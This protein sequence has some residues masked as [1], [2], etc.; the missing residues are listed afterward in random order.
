MSLSS[1]ILRSVFTQLL[2]SSYERHYDVFSWIKKSFF[3]FNSLCT[4]S[5]AFRTN[6]LEA[7]HC[8]LQTEHPTIS[9]SKLIEFPLF[10]FPLNPLN[11][12]VTTSP[13]HPLPFP[14]SS[15]SHL[16][17]VPC[18]RFTEIP[19][20]DSFFTTSFPNL[21]TLQI[22]LSVEL[23][24]MS[25]NSFNLPKL[26]S[27]ILS[28]FVFHQQL[29]DFPT[30]LFE[31]KSIKMINC[32][33]D[34][35]IEINIGSL[36]LLES[37][38][39]SDLCG[40]G[41]VVI[42]GLKI[43]LKFLHLYKGVKFNN[44]G[45][46]L[47]IFDKLVIEYGNDA[48]FKEIFEIFDL[49]ICTVDL[50]HCKVKPKHFTTLRPLIENFQIFLVPSSSLNSL[51]TV[52]IPNLKNLTF[53]VKDSEN[54]MLKFDLNECKDY[55][56]ILAFHNISTQIFNFPPIL[57]INTLSISNVSLKFL[58]QLLQLTPFLINLYASNISK[59]LEEFEN[60]NLKYLKY[61]DL[62]T[63]PNSLTQIF[64]PKLANLSV[65]SLENFS[66]SD[67][68]NFP[69]LREVF[70]RHCILQDDP[71]ENSSIVDLTFQDCDVTCPF[72]HKFTNLKIL[73]LNIN[74][75]ETLNL[76][77]PKSIKSLFYYGLF[78]PLRE[79]ISNLDQ[80]IF[81][82]G[83]I[84]VDGSS[85]QRNAS[86]WIEELKFHKSIS[87][88]DISLSKFPSIDSLLENLSSISTESEVS[89][90]GIDDL[91]ED[92]GCRMVED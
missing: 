40:N 63:C 77:L 6:F 35:I 79:L 61:L 91:L 59:D 26:Q 57:F 20:L 66:F 48:L 45:K 34:T 1:S 56:E 51:R 21:T 80:I 46:N 81:L 64:A 70:V 82:R 8:F 22:K 12:N 31:L 60:F 71:I 39:I 33:V 47:K 54:S 18:R 42:S 27:L 37:L 74:E 44:S 16:T 72:F 38:E 58:M 15:I 10:I 68:I 69:A 4:V 2:R 88:I 29:I 89:V 11:L 73:R 67:L 24:F 17:L 53:S 28:D 25:F 5:Q 7:L 13:C 9:L 90:M 30:S 19:S 52:S 43:N 23:D 76:T 36:T 65:S 75:G 14:P 87:I 83:K 92:L 41:N 32:V 85:E 86:L 78:V 84:I 3:R 50:I 55:L 62:R 49:N